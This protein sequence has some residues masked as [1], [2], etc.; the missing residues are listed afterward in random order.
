M[1][2][3]RSFKM[4]PPFYYL[5]RDEVYSRLKAKLSL[6]LFPQLG[7]FALKLLGVLVEELAAVGPAV[8]GGL[9]GDFAVYSFADDVDFGA[10]ETLLHGPGFPLLFLPLQGLQPLGRPLF[11]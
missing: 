9:G 4:L 1:T 6:H 10:E 11:S 2:L 3:L 7:P 8:V 5:L